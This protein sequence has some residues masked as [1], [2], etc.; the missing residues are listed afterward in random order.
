M[1]GAIVD[2]LDPFED[3]V[4]LVLFFWLENSGQIG[5]QSPIKTFHRT[6]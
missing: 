2:E 4:S 1:H 6:L 3:Y 5:F